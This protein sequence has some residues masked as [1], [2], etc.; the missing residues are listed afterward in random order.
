MNIPIGQ[1]DLGE[2]EWKLRIVTELDSALNQWV[3]S[4]PDHRKFITLGLFRLPD[5]RGCVNSPLGPESRGRILP[6]AICRAF[7]LLLYA[8]DCG[9]PTLHNRKPTGSHIFSFSHNMY[10]RRTVLH[11]CYGY[12]VPPHRKGTSKAHGM[13]FNKRMI[14]HSITSCRRDRSSAQRS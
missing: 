14:F 1:Q 6:R 5:I 4:L 8:A 9:T 3:D 2:R 7:C 11:P 12:F 10:Q 13:L